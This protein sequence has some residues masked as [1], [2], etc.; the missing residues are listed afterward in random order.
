MQLV[1]LGR[2]WIA[3]EWHPPWPIVAN[4]SNEIGLVK[5]VSS[6]LLRPLSPLRGFFLEDEM[7]QLVFLSRAAP[8]RKAV[9]KDCAESGI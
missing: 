3:F 4:I 6:R 1:E 8:I 7:I 9:K 2:S 5:N